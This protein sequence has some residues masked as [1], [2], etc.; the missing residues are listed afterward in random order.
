MAIK[1]FSKSELREDAP[2][3][4]VNLIVVSS[5]LTSYSVSGCDVREGGCGS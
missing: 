3:S 5:V 1:I 2:V 4:S